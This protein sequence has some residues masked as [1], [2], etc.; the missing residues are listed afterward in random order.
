MNDNAFKTNIFTPAYKRTVES[1]LESS[2]SSFEGLTNE[3]AASRLEQFGSNTLP[4]QKP[5]SMLVVFLRQFQSPLIYV[6]LASGVAISFLEQ[7]KDGAVIA[8]V[9]L[10]NALIGSFQEGKAQSV[11]VALKNFVQ[12]PATVLRDRFEITI[13]DKQVVPGDLLILNEGD[14]IAADARIISCQGLA[15]N[16]SSLTGESIPVN[17]VAQ[18]IPTEKEL[19]LQDQKNMVF[20]GTSVVAG[21]ATALVIHTGINTEIGKIAANLSVQSEELPL[22]KD[23]NKLSSLIIYVTFALCGLLIILGLIYGYSFQ[24]IVS[25]SI[26]LAISVIPEG[27]PIAITLIL[28]TG[29]W[30]MSKRNALIKKLAAVEGLGQAHV[31]ATDKTGTLTKNELC[32]VR[33]FTENQ[34]FE[35]TGSGYEPEGKLEIDA[36]A[37]NTAIIKDLSKIGLIAALCN[38]CRLSFDSKNGLWQITGDPTEAA[39]IT[40]GKKIGSDKD[41]LLEQITIKAEIP[42]DY[43]KRFRAMLINTEEGTMLIALGAPEVIIASSDLSS[44]AKIKLIAQSEQLSTQGLRV[45]AGGYKQNVE[46]LD[47]DALPKLEFGALFALSDTL[48]EDV[49]VTVKELQNAGLQV[50][51]I[52]GDNKLTATAIAKQAGVLTEQ[53]QVLTGDELSSLNTTELQNI[54]PQVQVFARVTPEYKLKIIEAYQKIG[55]IIAMTGDGVNDVPA[56]TKADLGIA[57]GKTGTEV[58]KEAADIILLDDNLSSIKAAVEEGRNIYQ[59]IQK[60]IV[61]LFS[62][63]AG[64]VLTIITA[65]ILSLPMPIL[66]TQIIW[67][68]FVT[69]GFFT[70][71]L[72]MEPRESSLLNGAYKKPGKYF[73]NKKSF[74]QI[75]YMAVTMSA[76]SLILF[77]MYLPQG[78]R[79]AVSVCLTSL[80]VFQWMNVL[81]CRSKESVFKQNP[82]SNLWLFASFIIVFALQ[83]AALNLPFFQKL[84]HTQSL[85]YEEWVVIL[86][87][88]TAIIWVEEVRKVLSKK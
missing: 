7:F 66:P 87:T 50:V 47:T 51:M 62:T 20:K 78:Y 53:G 81:N 15:V 17:K 57:M 1:L 60:V 73:I 36:K 64:E 42:F 18:E 33:I 67:L 84:L 38:K 69:D 71:A 12:T 44:E 63:N 83:I 16:E 3:E 4:E 68:N 11:L 48:H 80:A 61:Y 76:G 26:S 74:S 5:D 79:K 41:I 72:A 82:F 70:V 22:Q 34:L 52:T 77:Y 86:L 13:Q 21:S 58:T 75:F 55:K 54:L 30:R 24:D 19:I 27:L 59:T 49:D 14:K 39:M 46:I 9:L 88:S 2:G 29:V 28:A 35:V 85:N 6:L 23:F 56:L 65:I 37:I 25:T 45:L 31:I 32:V 10:L 8:I 40:F 43:K